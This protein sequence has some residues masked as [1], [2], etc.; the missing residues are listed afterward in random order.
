MMLRYDPDADALYV[1]LRRLED[2]EVVHHTRRLDDD[3]NVDYDAGE[4]VIGVEFL[5]VSDGLNLEGVPAAD[6]IR[7]AV[8]SFPR[9]LVPA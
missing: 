2:G 6:A 8:E 9:R 5:G 7:R 1:S 4:G 3:R